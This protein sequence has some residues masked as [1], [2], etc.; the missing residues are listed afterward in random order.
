MPCKTASFVVADRRPSSL[1]LVTLDERL[2]AAARKEG[3]AIMTI[4]S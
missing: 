3:F 4:N 1:E 2:A